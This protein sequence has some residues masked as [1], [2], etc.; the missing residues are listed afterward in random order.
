MSLASSCF[1]IFMLKGFGWT[2]PKMAVRGT[3]TVPAWG[4]QKPL[5]K[6]RTAHAPCG[7]R[8]FSPYP[9]CSKIC[10][11]QAKNKAVKPYDM[12]PLRYYFGL[13]Y[14]AKDFCFS[15]SLYFWFILEGGT[16]LIA[17]AGLPGLEP[18][19]ALYSWLFCDR[20]GIV[21]LL[22]PFPSAIRW[23]RFAGSGLLA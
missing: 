13:F 23:S 22:H 20:P 10:D 11:F 6:D 21:P 16:C 14:A 17:H 18:G 15:R 12:Y 3:V 5:Q 4:S 1:L 8:A 7:T 9:F 19:T 2:P